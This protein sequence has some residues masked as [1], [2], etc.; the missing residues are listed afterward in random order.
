[1]PEQVCFLLFIVFFQNK[2]PLWDTSNTSKQI[3]HMCFKTLK[4]IRIKLKLNIYLT[5]TLRAPRGV[6][7]VAGANAYAAKFA[8]S[9]APTETRA[10]GDAGESSTTWTLLRPT[11]WNQGVGAWCTDCNITGRDAE[12]T[13]PSPAPQPTDK[14]LCSPGARPHT[15]RPCYPAKG[16]KPTMWSTY[17]SSKALSVKMIH[18]LEMSPAHHS[19][20]FK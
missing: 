20:S 3:Y 1:M 17:F 7:K 14:D 11:Y 16:R 2:S 15:G 5:R 10:R 19:H 6:T 9:P 8:A 13:R 18:L 12:P 4:F